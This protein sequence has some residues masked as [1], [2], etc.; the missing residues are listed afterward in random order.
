MTW[1][2]ATECYYYDYPDTSEKS[3]NVYNYKGNVTC[4]TWTSPRMTAKTT[5]THTKRQVKWHP[6][7]DRE[8]NSC[9][10]K[11]TRQKNR[12]GGLQD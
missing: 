12:S 4:K 6:D 11:Q 10:H 9:S 3:V 2:I 1:N 5:A 7:D 8:N